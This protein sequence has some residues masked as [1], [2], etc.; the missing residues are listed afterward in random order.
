MVDEQVEN[1]EYALSLKQSGIVEKVIVSGCLPMRDFDAVQKSYSDVDAFLIL[2]DFKKEITKAMT[3]PSQAE[4]KQPLTFKNSS[5]SPK[6]IHLCKRYHDTDPNENRNTFQYRILDKLGNVTTD[7]TDQ[8]NYSPM[9][10][11]QLS[12][13]EDGTEEFDDAIIVQAGYKIQYR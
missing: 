8:T 12:A 9:T 13:A 11:V 7:W 1:I 5:D 10:A 6:I 3:Y 4:L 2:K